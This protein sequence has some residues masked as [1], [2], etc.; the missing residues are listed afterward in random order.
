MAESK[1]VGQVNFEVRADTSKLAGDMDA[2]RTQVQQAATTNPA[3]D[4][5]SAEIAYRQAEQV[6]KLQNDYHDL[7]NA[8]QQA[9]KQ[10]SDAMKATETS[11]LE[12][13]FALR[14]LIGKI[15]GLATVIGTAYVATKS[16]FDFMK[17]G[18][19]EAAKK[20]DA[21][22]APFQKP[23]PGDN[24][25]TIQ[26]ELQ[27]VQELQDQVL[28][29]NIEGFKAAYKLQR[30]F[31][32]DG[33]Q[34]YK[35]R[36]EAERAYMM[37]AD[38]DADQAKIDEAEKAAKEIADKA[39]EEE[40][41]KAAKIAE[42]RISAQRAVMT[43]EEKIQAEAFDK[44]VEI[45]QNKA[46]NE[47]EQQLADR[48]AA[49]DAVLALEQ[50]ALAKLD[51]AKKERA[52]AEQDRIEATAKAERAEIQ[53]TQDMF[54][55]FVRTQAQ[56]AK[57]LRDQNNQVFSASGIEANAGNVGIILTTLSAQMAGISESLVQSVKTSPYE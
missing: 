51:E 23:G 31:G 36:L 11:I 56:A 49:I 35:E 57:D 40:R 54:E 42:I 43:D 46:K 12:A 22:L 32:T 1:K 2:A 18:A 14:T 7:G 21:F 45:N 16:L 29:P 19:D 48:R 28:Q 41:N 24:L 34:I 6:K 30:E 3:I 44:I 39:A 55:Q 37:S 8:S 13:G 15:A 33:V 10:A 38:A 53:R 25:R 5:M 20:A 50:A 26:K 4:P 27:R 9:G 17:S 47:T 52:K